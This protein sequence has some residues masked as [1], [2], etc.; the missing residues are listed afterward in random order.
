MAIYALTMAANSRIC[1][2]ICPI[3]GSGAVPQWV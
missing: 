1:E 3:L 2:S